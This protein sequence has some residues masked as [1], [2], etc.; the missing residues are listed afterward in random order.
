M[1]L[2]PVRLPLLIHRASKPGRDAC[3][4]NLRDEQAV[5][6]I[7]RGKLIREGQIETLEIC[8]R[9]AYKITGSSRETMYLVE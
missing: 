9:Q 5:S 4:Y 2:I 3:L 7:W 8:R 1:A 6:V